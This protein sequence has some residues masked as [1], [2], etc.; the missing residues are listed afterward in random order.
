MTYFTLCNFKEGNDAKL[1]YDSHSPNTCSHLS[2]ILYERSQPRDQ[3]CRKPPKPTWASVHVAP[4]G[5][6]PER[7]AVASHTQLEKSLTMKGEN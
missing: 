4:R 2:L 6:P 5:L 7:S 3:E 1:T